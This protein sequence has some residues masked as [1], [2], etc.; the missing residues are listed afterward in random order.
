MS[1]LKIYFISAFF[2]LLGMTNCALANFFVSDQQEPCAT[3][4]CPNNMSDKKWQSP[5]L[6]KP[7]CAPCK[8]NKPCSTM[9]VNTSPCNKTENQTSSSR[10]IDQMSFKS[11]HCTPPPAS[12]KLVAIIYDGSLKSNTER[13]AKQFGW[14]RIVWDVPVDYRW[15]GTAKV[16]GASLPEIMNVILKQFPLEITFYYANHIAVVTPRK[17]YYD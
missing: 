3:K 4:R 7:T 17:Y 15:I 1:N 12:K 13:I 6:T 14:N 9:P 8:T 16:T 11:P 2:V 10:D 5:T